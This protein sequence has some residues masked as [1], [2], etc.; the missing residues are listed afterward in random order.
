MLP[1][2]VTA[3]LIVV[4]ERDSWPVVHANEDKLIALWILSLEEATPTHV[5]RLIYEHPS[6]AI[7]FR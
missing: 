3:R 1:E 5:C 2:S 7:T 4:V 6:R